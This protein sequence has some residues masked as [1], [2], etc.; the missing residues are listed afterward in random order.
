MSSKALLTA[1]VGEE[2]PRQ[3]LLNDSLYIA[4]CACLFLVG[5]SGVWALP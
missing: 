2:F 4:S 3:I 5:V 1:T